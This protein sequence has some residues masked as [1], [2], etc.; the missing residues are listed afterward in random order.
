MHDI[1]SCPTSTTAF[2]CPS[3]QKT[4][5]VNIWVFKC[6][7]IEKLDLNKRLGREKTQTNACKLL[8]TSVIPTESVRVLCALHRDFSLLNH[9]VYP[10]TESSYWVT[11][12]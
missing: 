4:S 7:N 1:L 10:N 2:F 6:G 11:H 8:H 5:F 9:F 3:K 12:C